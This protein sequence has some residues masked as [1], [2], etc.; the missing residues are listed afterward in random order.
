LPIGQRRHDEPNKASIGREE[1][2]IGRFR[3]FVRYSVYDWKNERRPEKSSQKASVNPGEA[4][5]PL[6]LSLS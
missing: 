1:T 6:V 3:F 2:K 4:L 5:K